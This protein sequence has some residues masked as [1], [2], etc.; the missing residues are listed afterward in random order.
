LRL[1]IHPDPALRVRCRPVGGLVAPLAA[2]AARLIEIMN[3]QRG[4]GL[5]APQAGLDFR[6]FVCDVPA[7]DEDASGAATPPVG[8]LGT[9]VC[10]DPVLTDPSPERSP[11]DEGC[12]SIPGVR[13]DVVRPEQVTLTATGLDG[14]RFTIR[15]GGLLARCVQHECDHLD[16]VLIIDRMTQMSR[17]KNRRRLRELEHTG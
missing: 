8:G 17:L 7:D 2:V 15:A 11:F 16:G 13:G 1:R 12:L 14:Q 6:L 10:I 4:I 5:A 3:E 9:L